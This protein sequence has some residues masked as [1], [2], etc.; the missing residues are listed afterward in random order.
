MKN[1]EVVGGRRQRQ[2]REA[3]VAAQMLRSN[4]IARDAVV[5]GPAGCALGVDAG[6]PS[7]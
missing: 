1:R 6:E 2:R 7:G 4:L 3:G 5:E